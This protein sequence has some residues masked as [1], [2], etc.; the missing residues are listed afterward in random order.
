MSDSTMAHSRVTHPTPPGLRMLWSTDAI[1]SGIERVADDVAA[2]F[3]AVGTVNLIPVMTGAMPFAAALATALEQRA[4]GHWLI[5]PVFASAYDGDSAVRTPV[6]EFPPTFDRR[7]DPDAPVLLIDDILDTATTMRALLA[8]FA[9]RG[10]PAVRVAV[11]IDRPTRRDTPLEP[12][13]HAFTLDEDHWL[14][15]FGMD[16]ERRYRGLDAIYVREP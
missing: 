4:P 9:V 16:S 6:I 13:F 2:A 15:G 7:V 10:F 11:L 5:A 3:E 1:R 12:D 8:A 14:V